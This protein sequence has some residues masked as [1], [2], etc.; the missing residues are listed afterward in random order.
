MAFLAAAL[1]LSGQ[2]VA[3]DKIRIT[4]SNDS[5]L[6][7]PIYAAEA[8]GYFKQNGLDVERLHSTS[9]PNAIA[10]LLA[11]DIEMVMGV[12][13]SPMLARKAGGDIKMIAGVASQYGVNVAITQKWADAHNVK[14]D[15]TYQQRLA[16]LKGITIGV[17]GPGGGNDQLVSYLAEQAGLDRSRD[18]NVVAL[19]DGSALLAAFS[20]GTV[21]AI[22]ISTPHSNV[23]PV[24]FG[25][26]LLFNTGIGDVEPLRG[27]FGAAVSAR[28]EWLEKNPDVA[29]RFVK[30]LQMG[31][32]AMHDPART[33][34]VKVAIW[35]LVFSKLDQSLFTQI[36]HDT[37]IGTPTTTL[38]TDKMLED[39]IDFG[40]RFSKNKLDNSIVKES[41]TNEYAPAA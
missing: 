34:E 17:T 39:L 19:G 15:S 24:T 3:Q 16:A 14:A 26:L 4:S 29:R 32:D 20:Q 35:K 10:A 12:P 28:G 7:N 25:G 21:D 23:A 11:G 27:F 41:Y 2:A 36:W 22:S 9:G 13:S 1:L 38:I 5:L 40:N 6:Y 8:M 37:I 18:M 31:L 30:S 33:E